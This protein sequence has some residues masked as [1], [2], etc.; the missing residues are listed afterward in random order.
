MQD[1]SSQTIDSEI[2]AELK[3]VMGED[4]TVLVSSFVRDGRQRLQ[5]LKS[6]L[7]DQDRE[8]L[9]SQAHSLKGSSSNLGAVQVCEQ[10]MALEALAVDG[11]LAQAGAMLEQL[12]T[13]FQQACDAL[14]SL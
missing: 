11:D 12:E 6:A 5:A 14:E 9:R 2:V 4:F 13:L 8:G 10:S 3:D 1:S 7:A